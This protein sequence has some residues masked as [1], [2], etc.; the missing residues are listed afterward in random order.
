MTQKIWQM[1]VFAQ[2]DENNEV[3]YFVPYHNA[4]K[5][6]NSKGKL[7]TVANPSEAHMNVAGWY[8][9]INVQEDGTDYI[10]DNILYHY[11]GFPVIDEEEGD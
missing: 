11:V 1:Y 7:V 4:L 5:Y 2:L 10:V 9:L 3:V 8:R 6:K